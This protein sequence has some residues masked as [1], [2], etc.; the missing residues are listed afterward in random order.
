VSAA[1]PIPLP[2]CKHADVDVDALLADDR[3]AAAVAA[4]VVP[5]TTEKEIQR[6]M[7]CTYR[8]IAGTEADPAAVCVLLKQRDPNL[9]HS[10]VLA[11]VIWKNTEEYAPIISKVQDWLAE[12]N[13]KLP[14]ES[15]TDIGN[16]RRLAVLSGTDIAHDSAA[17]WRIWADSAWIS[18]PNGTVVQRAAKGVSRMIQDEADALT[19][20]FHATTNEAHQ[21]RIKTRIE[22]TAPAARRAESSKLIGAMTTLVRD[23]PGVLT[24]PE[25]WDANPQL[26]ACPGATIELGLDGHT[27]REPRRADRLTKLTLG[28]PGTGGKAPLLEAFLRGRLPDREVRLFVQKLL[29]Y[30]LITGNPRRL[31]VIFLGK[32]S[33]GK[34]TV[35]EIV[36]HVLGDYAGPFNLS[37]F[38]GKMDEG[39]RSDVIKALG[40]RMIF[41]SEVSQRW[42]FHADEVKRLTG[43]DSVQA[44][45][46]YVKASA[47]VERRPAF[48][49]ILSANHVPT[50]RGA[51]FATRRRLLAV[52]FDQQV[53]PNHEDPELG[54]RI[55]T[56]E[57]DGVLDYLLHGYDMYRAVGLG[58]P[59][60]AVV[61]A[62]MKLHDSLTVQNHWLAEHTERDESYEVTSDALWGAFMEWCR[63]SGIPDDARGTKIGFGRTLGDLGYDSVKVDKQR[64][65]KGLRLARSQFADHGS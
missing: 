34:T 35:G 6:W 40:R 17:G 50:I 23:E 39:P 5:G 45:D 25:Q 32:T 10:C 60:Y 61:R 3:I 63:S 42:E 43:G 11:K 55:R 59:P 8:H 64:G 28:R 14:Q 33:T 65:W 24:R 19:R 46:L 12:P 47:T 16:A 7:V 54:E 15:M 4:P 38:R 30:G 44:R 41:A 26:I 58:E 56:Q 37:L 20:V 22:V 51:D 53:D 48:L 18:D 57:A 13:A 9:D 52:P 31:L 21:A 62:T 27:I 36:N 1:A 29:G 49:P 2:I